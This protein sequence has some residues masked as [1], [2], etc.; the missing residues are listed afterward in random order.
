M[1]Q[2]FEPWVGVYPLQRFSK[3]PL[4]ATQ[5]PHRDEI[6][7]DFECSEGI[8]GLDRPDCA[9]N[10]AQTGSDCPRQYSLGTRRRHRESRRS[11][12]ADAGADTP[13]AHHGS[14]PTFESKAPAW[15][16][17]AGQWLR[18]SWRHVMQPLRSRQVQTP[19]NGRCDRC[20]GMS[21]TLIQS[22]PLAP[23]SIPN[24]LVKGS[25]ACS[26]N[27]SCQSVATR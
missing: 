10:C 1:R 9:Q 18:T 24:H 27:I 13:E 11:L 14:L 23:D 21:N 3:P 25:L 22:L 4:S 15:P 7:R 2:G 17:R 19:A 16:F 8:V 6:P 26:Q 12:E 20:N 5:P